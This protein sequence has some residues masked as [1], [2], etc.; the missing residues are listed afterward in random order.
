MPLIYEKILPAGRLGVWHILETEAVLRTAAGAFPE[1]IEE[2]GSFKSESRRKQWLA[3][4][5][6]LSNLLR[7]PS[8]KV[9]YD[10]H[11]KPSLKGF[12]GYIS[13][14]HT[15]EYA[16]V[17]INEKGHAG[18][19]IEKLTPRIERVAERFLQEDELKHIR[20]VAERRGNE[21]RSNRGH[22]N[23]MNNWCGQLSEEESE[24]EVIKGRCDPQTELLHLYWCS[25]E[26]L[27][28]FYGNPLVDLKND[29]HI[30]AFDYFCSTQAT[31]AARV[32]GPEGIEDH[33]LQFE[34]I[35]DHMLVYTL[36]KQG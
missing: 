22:T 10:E 36:L 34:R 24:E 29:I 33:E 25:K 17:L 6:L 35:G 27:Y 30:R 8:V 7:L 11:G 18:V 5:A 13:F 21:L 19:D 1:V 20:Q 14:S 28:K 4:R 31:F 23:K 16:A 9:Y 32:N 26:A 2:I 15:R 12:A 3:C